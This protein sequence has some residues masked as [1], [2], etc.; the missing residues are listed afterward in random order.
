MRLVSVGFGSMVN[1]SR[2]IAILSPESAPIRRR[3]QEAKESQ[4]LVDATYGRKIRAV[5]IMD[6]D[7]VVVSAI[8]PET[9]AA[10][11]SEE[12]KGEDT[13]WK[14]DEEC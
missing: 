3:I 14:T 8:A 11:M 10:R 12:V 13:Q 4:M 9:I 6:S 7:H 5:I 1:V 2:I